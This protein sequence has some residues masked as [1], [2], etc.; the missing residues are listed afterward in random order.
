[1][2][3]FEIPALLAASAAVS[4][5]GAI[6]SSIGQ[7]KLANFNARVA[8]QDAASARQ[9]G[10]AEASRRRRAAARALGRQRAAFGAAGVTVEGSP[11]DLLED[12]AAE[13]EIEALDI[14]RRGI[15]RAREL[16]IGAQR[17]RFQAGVALEKGAFGATSQALSGSVSTLREF[18]KKEA[19]TLPRIGR[20]V[21]RSNGLFGS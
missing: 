10:E 5:A 8:E 14:R 20:S 2:S 4:T 16:S 11:L 7:A 17:S 13:Q 18:R 3:G 19:P 9:Q 15:L 12:L 1:M 21:T 6:T